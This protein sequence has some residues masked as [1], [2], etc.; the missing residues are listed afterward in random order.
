MTIWAPTTVITY[1][2]PHHSRLAAT[3]TSKQPT[4]RAMCQAM[5]PEVTAR[6]PAI[7]RTTCRT[8]VPL[9]LPRPSRLVDPPFSLR[10]F[11]RT[12]A[13]LQ[14]SR[15]FDHP[16]NQPPLHR[17]TFRRS[18]PNRPLPDRRTFRRSRPQSP[19]RLLLTSRCRSTPR[20]NVLQSPS[21]SRQERSS[22][23]A[24]CFHT[25]S[26]FPR[27][28]L[29]ICRTKRRVWS[30]R[31]LLT[32]TTRTPSSPRR[33]AQEPPSSARRSISAQLASLLRKVLGCTADSSASRAA[34][35]G[36]TTLRRAL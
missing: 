11:V 27:T 35:L 28:G 16:L 10:F 23:A 8:L 32:T 1:P 30:L 15:L 7:V 26:L 19:T 22:A 25:M 17:H 5:M 20:I 36:T 21:T 12:R 2:L 14:C 29:F 18:P 13:L 3:Y 31:M 34:L 33:T 9:T 4:Y 24:R 6:T